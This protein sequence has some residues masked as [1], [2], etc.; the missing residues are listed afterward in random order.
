MLRFGSELIFNLCEH[1]GTEVV[2][3]NQTEDASCEEDLAKD[4]LEIITM[5][6]AHLY[7]SR[8]HK[9]KRIVEELKAIADKL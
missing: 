6:S 2:I 1:F 7:G 5:F 8:N 9:N 4:L 3:I